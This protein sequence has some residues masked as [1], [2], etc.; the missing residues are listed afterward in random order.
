VTLLTPPSNVPSGRGSR[1]PLFSD[2]CNQSRHGSN[3]RASLKSFRWT[4][5]GSTPSWSTGS[6][7]TFG[8]MDALARSLSLL[9]TCAPNKEKNQIKSEKGKM[10]EMSFRFCALLLPTQTTP[11]SSSF[12]NKISAY[13]SKMTKSI[14]SAHVFTINQRV[15]KLSN[16]GTVATKNNPKHQNI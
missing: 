11:P 5:N 16:R 4:V 2:G 15:K 13:L 12:F 6:E 1:I 7:G 3:Y 8:R 14:R 10:R 9:P